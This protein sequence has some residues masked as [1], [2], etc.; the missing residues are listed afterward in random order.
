MRDKITEYLTDLDPI[1][2]EVGEQIALEE[3][4]LL[5]TFVKRAAQAF[6]IGPQ[7]FLGGK[8]KGKLY[9]CLKETFTCV[10]FT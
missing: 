2:L 9:L 7:G 5:L 1:K 3:A 6:Y 10:L 8:L 4:A